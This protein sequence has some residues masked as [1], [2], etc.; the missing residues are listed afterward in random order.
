MNNVPCA[1]HDST[2]E[3][4]HSICDDCM[5]THFG[6]SA[7]SIHTEIKEEDAAVTDFN[8]VPS[9]AERFADDRRSYQR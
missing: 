6:V 5:E 3:G 8:G 9:Y 4:S 1:W 2:S 7:T